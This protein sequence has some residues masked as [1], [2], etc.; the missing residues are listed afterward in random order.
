MR[1]LIPS[2]YDVDKSGNRE[3]VERC[4]AETGRAM[5]PSSYGKA[6]FMTKKQLIGVSIVGALPGAALL[7]FL[8]LGLAQGML[9]DG[10]TVSVMLW[11]VWTLAALG[12][13]VATGLPVAILLFPGLMP[14]PSTATGTDNESPAGSG[15][16]IQPDE[17]LDDDEDAENDFEDA[18]DGEKMFDDGE[19]E[20]DFDDEYDSF[21]DDEKPLR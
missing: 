20:D 12:S 3:D 1:Q 6:A 18:D 13:L 5:V 7:I 15:S 21:D 19:I 14:E 11:I 2:P 4:S 17:S 10:A 16:A 9:A 8:I